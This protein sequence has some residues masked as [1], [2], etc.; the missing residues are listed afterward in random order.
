L[1]KKEMMSHSIEIFVERRQREERG[2]RG[3]RA[4]VLHVH[5]F[6]ISFTLSTTT[7]CFCI[8]LEAFLATFLPLR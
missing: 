1:K 2:D 7:P 3:Q 4:E 8:I 5:P 6:S